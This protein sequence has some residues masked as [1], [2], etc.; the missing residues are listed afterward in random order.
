MD[1][2]NRIRDT[3]AKAITQREALAARFYTL[4]FQ[5]APETQ[6]LFTGD[7]HA[8]GVKLIDTLNF[9]VD[10]LDD[11]DQLLPAARDLAI[12]HVSY[13]VAPEH[14]DVVGASLIEAMQSILGPDFDAAARQDWGSTYS[15]LISHMLPAA[16]P[17]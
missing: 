11:P 5:K 13:G 8:Q 1:S 12:R 4:L 7:M 6:V 3:W 2:H 17:A 15:G 10:H 14:Y 9:I 16:Y